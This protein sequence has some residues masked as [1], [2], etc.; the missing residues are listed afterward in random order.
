MV[1]PSTLSVTGYRDEAVPNTFLRQDGATEHLAILLP[2]IAY[3]CDLPLL[4]YPARLLAARG[5]DVLRVEYAYNRRPDF[6]ALANAGQAEWL[7]ADTAAACRAGLAQRAYRQIT[8][9]GKS[10]GTLAM[11]HLLTAQPELAGARA[12]WLTP[13]LRLDHLR[14]QI[15]QWS[16]PSLFVIGTA[17]PHYDQTALAE[18]Q[19]ATNGAAV[20]VAD[21]D[22]SLEI[23][24]DVVRSLQAMIE[25]V[26]AIQQ[27]VA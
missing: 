27:L 2:G 5:A 23:A 26:Q 16:G 6:A 8:L 19:A 4:Y 1:S 20:V 12:V 13:L 3:P 9:V 18:V 22:H 10:L 21:A 25:V 17:D 14:A 15:A 7:Y 24:G 11:G